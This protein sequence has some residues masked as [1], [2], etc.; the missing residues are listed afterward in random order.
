MPYK[1]D[2]DAWASG[3]KA[4]L[5]IYKDILKNKELGLEK[6][7][8]WYRFEDHVFRLSVF[9]D[10]LAKVILLQ[11]AGLDAKKIICRL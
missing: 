10:R 4:A 9:Q 1:F 6:L 5:S 8:D 3:S 11:K 2:G 7:T